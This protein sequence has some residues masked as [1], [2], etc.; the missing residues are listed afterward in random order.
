MS[1]YIFNKYRDFIW[2]NF[3]GPWV[4][5]KFPVEPNFSCFFCQFLFCIFFLNKFYFFFGFYQIFLGKISG[6]QVFAIFFL[7]NFPT[8]IN[9]TLEINPFPSRENEIVSHIK[10]RKKTCQWKKVRLIKLKKGEFFLQMI[11]TCTNAKNEFPG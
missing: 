10:K 2:M 6:A 4:F 7:S 8:Y 5:L 11:K 9:L 3:S 1:L